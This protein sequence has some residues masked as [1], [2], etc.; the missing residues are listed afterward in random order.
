[1]KPKLFFIVIDGAADN[2]RFGKTPFELAGTPGLDFLAKVGSNG[3]LKL[4]D[5]Y[6]PETDNGVM[7]LMGYDPLKY[8]TGRAPLE[9]LGIGVNFSSGLALRGNLATVRNGKIVDIRAGRI[10]TKDAK[11]L[12]DELNKKLK[13]FKDSKVRF[14]HA[15]NYRVLLHAEGKFSPLV[16]NTH[17][18]YK[19]ISESLEVPVRI[20]SKG[21]K[22]SKPLAKD[23]LARKTAEFINEISE[24]V[25]EI[26]SES[27]VNKRRASKG[28]LEANYILWRGAGVRLPKL[29][30]LPIFKKLRWYCI[31]DTPAERGIAK[32]LGMKLSRNLPNPRT[33]K[34]TKYSDEKTVRRAVR[35]DMKERFKKLTKAIRVYDA[36]YVHIKGPD[37]FGHAG[38]KDAKAWV[39]EEIDKNFVSKLLDEVDLDESLIVVTSD[40]ATVCEKKMHTADPV[41]VV[42]AGLNVEPDIVGSFNERLAKKG[43]LGKMKGTELMPFLQKIILR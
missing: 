6:P 24:V 20:T 38:K 40:H 33:D 5:K 22:K 28:S 1:M 12:V 14:Y 9:L 39:I 19:R 15:L 4:V 26:L 18:G 8:H 23:K 21:L 17:P 29:K 13:K 11:K 3:L 37:P 43:A 35:F 34:L 27:K 10:E 32:L 36:F 31:G 42:V 2:P 7:A 30:P 41:P 25:G 16:S